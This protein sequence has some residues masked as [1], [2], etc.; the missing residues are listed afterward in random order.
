MPNNNSS[1]AFTAALNSPG[2]TLTLD[3]TSSP[4]TIKINS[5]ALT[6]GT[7]DIGTGATLN[8]VNQP[9]GIT[10]I[11]LG[12]GLDVAGTFEVNGGPTSALAQ[13]GSVEGTLTVEGQTITATPGSGTFSNSGTVNLEQTTAF[14]I[15]GNLANSGAIYLGNGWH[16][17]GSNSLTVSGMLSNGG[18]I[19]LYAAGDS[20]TADLTNWGAIGLLGNNQTLTDTGDFNN[21]S[22]GSL[23]LNASLDTV[24]VA[25]AF[26]N[27]SGASVN[28]SGSNGTISVTGAFNNNGGSVTLSGSGDTLSAL[29]FNNSG[30]VSIGSNETLATTGVGGYTQTAGTTQVDGALA[31]STAHINGGT[32]MGVG[33]VN[34]SVNV[35]AG[36]TIKP[37]DSPGILTIIGNYFQSGTLLIDLGGTTPG[38][39]TGCYSRLVV[40][41]TA[42][43]GGTLDVDLLNGFTPTPGEDFYLL[44]STGGDSG[45]FAT[46][47]LP[48]LLNGD[49][50]NEIYYPASC[51]GGVSGCF[52][53]VVEAPKVVPEPSTWLL[54]GTGLLGLAARRRK[55]RNSSA[56]PRV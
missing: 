43:L 54:V 49:Y 24:S 34:G 16:D 6:A 45:S 39:C 30:S 56:K 47:D 48:T 33:T 13:L 52:E 12:A 36:G 55:K 10:D 25:G 40:V 20:L 18:T 31:T 5:L 41:G 7:L 32:L 50:W 42:S 2:N 8:L 17:T 35:G 22:G 23:A 38:T 46:L 4:T 51:P 3:S 53:L 37:G 27:A 9:N 1:T 14:T 11:P 44:T 21:N 29:A 15:A 19:A 28:M 26:N